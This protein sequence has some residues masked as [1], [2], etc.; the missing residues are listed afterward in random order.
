MVE[1]EKVWSV[2][3]DEMS[4]VEGMFVRGGTLVG[5]VE[6]AESE[7]LLPEKQVNAHN[8]IH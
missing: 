2:K 7:V 3:I 6:V 5:A 1:L 8:L 4:S